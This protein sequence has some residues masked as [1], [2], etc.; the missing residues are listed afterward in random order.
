M[1]CKDNE[2]ILGGGLG[3]DDFPMEFKVKL[4]FEHS[5]PRDR[6]MIENMFNGAHGRLYAAP[7]D[8]ILNVAGKEVQEYGVMPTGP[9]MHTNIKEVAKK[10]DMTKEH[11][12][13]IIA[14]NIKE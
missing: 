13:N 4:H 2:F 6:E 8:D 14:L 12:A 3:Y 10:V 5:K 9:G 7:A 1:I 11:V